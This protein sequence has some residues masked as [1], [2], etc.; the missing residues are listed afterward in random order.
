M[1][2]FTHK[3]IFFMINKNIYNFIE[4]LIYVLKIII[5]LLLIGLI[6]QYNNNL[7]KNLKY[8]I[9]F[10]FFFL[11]ISLIFCYYIITNRYLY[12]ILFLLKIN[13]FLYL[14]FSK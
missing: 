2:F 4:H 9:K 6:T 8:S 1:E 3:L 13:D 11:Y 12:K 7:K 10:L 14:L 5:Q